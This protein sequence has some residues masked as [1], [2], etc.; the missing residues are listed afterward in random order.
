[1]IVYI[2]GFQMPLGGHGKGTKRMAWYCFTYAQQMALMSLMTI[3]K[4]LNYFRTVNYTRQQRITL[5]E[6]VSLAGPYHLPGATFD[7]T[8]S[9]H[10]PSCQGGVAPTPKSC[11][12]SFC[13]CLQPF[14]CPCCQPHT[15]SV[16]ISDVTWVNCLAWV[17]LGLCSAPKEDLQASSA[18]LLYGQLLCVPRE[19]LQNTAASLLTG[20]HQARVILPMLLSW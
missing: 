2:S 14:Y 13:V 10:L 6:F 15:S 16:C 5:P 11:F 12:R 8:R 3:K 20:V 1:M 7:F 19:C 18:Q 9:Q 17:L 4:D